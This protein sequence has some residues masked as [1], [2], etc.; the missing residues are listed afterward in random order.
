MQL[1]ADSWMLIS[2]APGMI[3]TYD[4]RI[5]NPVLYPLSYEGTFNAGGLFTPNQP[6]LQAIRSQSKFIALDL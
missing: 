1:D 3:R 2:G 4:T 5:G 6:S